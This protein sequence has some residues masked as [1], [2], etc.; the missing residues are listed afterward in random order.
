M[1]FLNVMFAIFFTA[2]GLTL[3]G[4]PFVAL[5]AQIAALV[6][7]VYYIVQCFKAA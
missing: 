1:T 4:L 6:I 3:F 2:F 5:I 7:G